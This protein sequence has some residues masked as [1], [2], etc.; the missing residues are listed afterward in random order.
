METY[1]LILY[2]SSYGLLLKIA[3]TRKK[4]KLTF[5]FKILKNKKSVLY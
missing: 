5:G 4:P 1:V 2:E 3:E